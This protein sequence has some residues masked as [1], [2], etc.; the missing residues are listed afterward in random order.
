MRFA[1]VGRHVKVEVAANTPEC[2][3]WVACLPSLAERAVANIIQN[4]VEHNQEGGHVAIT[5]QLLNGG[6]R[7]QLSVID[8]GSGM[9]IETLASLQN[10]SFILDE[11]RSRG[12]GMGML[13]TQEVANR[14]GWSVSY[15]QLSPTG[16]EVRLEGQVVSP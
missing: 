8:D 5:L 10:K 11:A 3:I 2:E 7:Y 14:A 6:K 16:L 12:P 15:I 9:P 4:A 13:I 1:I